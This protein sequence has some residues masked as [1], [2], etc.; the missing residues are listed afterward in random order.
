M[1]LVASTDVV[2]PPIPAILPVPVLGVV[3]PD[4]KFQLAMVVCAVAPKTRMEKITV[5][6]LLFRD[7]FIILFIV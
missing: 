6:R 1:P 7:V 4:S 3:L 2:I 5:E